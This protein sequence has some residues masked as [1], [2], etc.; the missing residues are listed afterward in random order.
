[1]KLYLIRHPESIL[2]KDICYGASD[3]PAKPEALAECLANIRTQLTK[4]DGIPIY[5]S[6]LQRCTALA[7]ALQATLPASTLTIC[8]ELQELHFGHWEGLSWDTI[9]HTDSIGLDAWAAQTL[10]YAPGG[11]ESLMQLRRRVMHWLK[12]VCC[13]TTKQAIVITHGGPLRVLLSMHENSPEAMLSTK[14][15][16]W[17]SLNVIETTL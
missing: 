7:L 10:V 15:P 8:P 5:S 17:G 16:P 13:S 11:G 2:G 3:I 9:Y 6:P 14:A 4:L 12:N 1:L